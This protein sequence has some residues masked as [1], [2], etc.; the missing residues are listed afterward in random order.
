MVRWRCHTRGRAAHSSNPSSGDNAIYRMARVIELFERFGCEIL[1]RQAN[2]LLCGQPTLSIGTIA[3]GSGINTVPERC[4]IEIDYRLLPGDDPQTAW[5]RAID[6][7]SEGL[8]DAAAVQHVEHDPPLM[9]SGGLSDAANRPLAD[10]LASVVGEL[11]GSAARIGVPFGTNAAVI[12]EAGVPTVVFGPGSIE[13]AH[14][15]DEWLALDQVWQGREIVYRMM[16]GFEKRGN[17][18]INRPARV[19]GRISD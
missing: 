3:G 14:T 5:R 13:Q 1:P 7:V 17:L 2:H 11:T 9:Y 18:A 4:T 19:S 12:S 16:R 10:R 6:Y 15:A 8:G